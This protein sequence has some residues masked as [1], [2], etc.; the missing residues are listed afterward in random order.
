MHTLLLVHF[1]EK[2]GWTGGQCT[3]SPNG[4]TRHHA[5]GARAGHDVGQ[6]IHDGDVTVSSHQHE[7]DAAAVET[8]VEDEVDHFACMFP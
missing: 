6:R 2:E 5:A 4:H 7:E 8:H 1:S 3:R